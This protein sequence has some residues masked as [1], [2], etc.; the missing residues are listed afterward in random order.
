MKIS[1]VFNSFKFKMDIRTLPLSRSREMEV[2]PTFNITVRQTYCPIQKRE[3][4]PSSP[5]PPKPKV[6]PPFKF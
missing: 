6:Q 5:D 2:F 3:V 1:S 4:P